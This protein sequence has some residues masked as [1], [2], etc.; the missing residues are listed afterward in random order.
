MNTTPWPRDNEVHLYGLA[1][2]NDPV[3]LVRLGG[4]LTTSETERAGLLRSEQAKMRYIAGRG[5]LREILGGYLGIEAKTVQLVTGAHGKPFLAGAEA[6]LCFNLAH[7]GDNYLLAVAA[8]REVGIDI[9]RII[10]GKPLG[11]MTRMV[12][13]RHE[14][15]QLAR[16]AS[17][18]LEA[19]F[20]RCW[21]RKE[22]CLKAC[23]TG[24]SLPSNSFDVSPL[25]EATADM[26]VSCNQQC[27]QV[28]DLDMPPRYCAA[29]AVESV[30]STRHPIRV[31]WVDHRL[32]TTFVD[33]NRGAS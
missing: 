7:S 31:V 23:G 1:L 26:I 21:V 16:L 10:P 12:F 22:A 27:L 3:E 5:V 20:Y 33:D 14:Q 11:D 30:C 24:F 6:N 13:S 32:A 8:N 15:E 25:S 9:E 17:T 19:A 29:M 4:F 2:P 18:H 28:L